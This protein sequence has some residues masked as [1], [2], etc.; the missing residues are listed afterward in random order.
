MTAE[1]TFE[2]INSLALP[3]FETSGMTVHSLSDQDRAI[4]R[5]E[6][7]PGIERMY[8]EANGAR[9]R[10]ILDDFNDEIAKYAD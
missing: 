3:A 9:G 7:L 8:I 10:A 2:V 6:V 4:L 5:A 1:L